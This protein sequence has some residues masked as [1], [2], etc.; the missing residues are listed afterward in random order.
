[1]K[2]TFTSHEKNEQ[3]WDCDIIHLNII[4]L[5]LIYKV[6]LQDKNE[7]WDGNYLCVFMFYG[8][9]NTEMDEQICI[10]RP[11]QGFGFHLAHN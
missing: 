11:I 7:T 2:G 8:S 1:M 9:W 4:Q 3:Y 10:I 5:S 6:D